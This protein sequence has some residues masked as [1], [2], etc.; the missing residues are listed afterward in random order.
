VACSDDFRLVLQH[1]VSA[2]ADPDLHW[3]RTTRDHP[4]HP[5]EEYAARWAAVARIVSAALEPVVAGH[6]R[7]G[8]PLVVEGDAVWPALAA[9]DGFG[10]LAAE[11]RV[12][13]LF[14]VEED[15]DTVF[16]H[17]RERSSRTPGYGF[18]TAPDAEVLHFGRASCAYGSLIAAEAS[19]LGLPVLAPRP[20][21]TLLERAEVA[22]SMVAR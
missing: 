3:F 15:P 13:A 10:G 21:M 18:A 4:H 17:I 5:T 1:G 12:R 7:L 14:L 22:V 19:R 2:E 16:G 20:W 11:G 9:Q 8:E 6:L